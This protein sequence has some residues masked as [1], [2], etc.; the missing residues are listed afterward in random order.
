MTI[1]PQNLCDE[2]RERIALA[3]GWPQA[4]VDAVSDLLAQCPLDAAA[5]EALGLALKQ[6][7]LGLWW[8]HVMDHHRAAY[9]AHKVQAL[10]RGDGLRV[11]DVLS[12]TG[13]VARALRSRGARVHEVERLSMFPSLEPADD[14]YDLDT[15]AERVE[16]LEVDVVL[17]AASMHHEVDLDWLIG[18]LSRLR[19]RQFL[20]IENLRSAAM[21]SEMHARFDWFFN[22][23][24]NQFGADC[25]GRYYTRE[26]W[27]LLLSSLG[28]CQWKCE[29]RDVP[30]MPFPYD[31]FLVT[32]D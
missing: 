26:Q 25:P 17:V 13:T 18:W 8:N 6:V 4:R 5:Q 2:M 1:E 19:T 31:F 28:V 27:S 9:L 29:A 11:L 24:L 22:R 32:R 12:G 7:E 15:E 3:V 21:T 20:I 14:R 23:C 30:G 16:N 10:V